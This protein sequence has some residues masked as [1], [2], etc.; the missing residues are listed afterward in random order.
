MQTAQ[1]SADPH[2]AQENYG[3]DLTCEHLMEEFYGM[4]EPRLYGHTAVLKKKYI[5]LNTVYLL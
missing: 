2:E 4:I 5:F 1:G 3:S